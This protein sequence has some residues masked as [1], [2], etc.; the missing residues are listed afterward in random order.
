MPRHHHLTSLLLLCLSVVL[1]GCARER[2]AASPASYTATSAAKIDSAEK[3]VAMAKEMTER[4]MGFHEGRRYGFAQVFT[5]TASVPDFCEKGE[6][7]WVVRVEP[8]E[9]RPEKGEAVD[10]EVWFKDDGTYQL[11]PR[12]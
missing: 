1:S 5:A 12:P 11:I 8:F 4:R 9:P 10:A 7:V 3:A 6:R 2:A